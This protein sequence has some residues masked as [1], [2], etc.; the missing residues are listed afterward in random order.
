MP[1]IVEDDGIYC[2]PY[3]LPIP[4]RDAYGYT[5]TDPYNRVEADAG[6]VVK[7]QFKIDETKITCY[8]LLESCDI[9]WLE[10]FETAVLNQ[11][12]TW[13]LVPIQMAGNIQHYMCQFTARPKVTRVQGEMNWVDLAFRIK[14]RVLA[15]V[16]GI[17][18]GDRSTLVEWPSNMPVLQDSYSYE[19]RKTDMQNDTQ[20][21]TTRRPEF[22]IDEVKMTCKL[23]LS[24]T[25]IAVFEW[26]EREILNMGA[27]WFKMP[28]WIG[29]DLV[30]Y[31]VRMR[32]RPQMSLDGFWTDVSFELDL[33]QRD[34]MHPTV[35]Q[36]LLYISPD[37]LFW[38]L[39][40]FHNLLH[41]KMP[42][43]TII[44]DGV[45]IKV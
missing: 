9:E 3:W 33:E 24:M 4:E 2:W 36:W 20:L 32:G 35:V 12:V 13:F 16:D 1:N 21:S 11:G 39:N 10:A 8:V 5:L 38:F 7:P 34:L 27:R 45:Y 42:G 14:S 29:G 18:Y 40:E 22:N 30:N 17:L 15:P 43:L 44:P 37:E 23:S 41:V 25:Q 28:V 26:F 19:V 6:S 31:I